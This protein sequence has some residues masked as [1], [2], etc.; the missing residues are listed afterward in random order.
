[1]RE[2]SVRERSVREKPEPK[3]KSKEPPTG[4]RERTS[5]TAS[6]SD[7]RDDA[8]LEAGQQA[9]QRNMDEKAV[10]LAKEYA[11]IERQMLLHQISLLLLF[12]EDLPSIVLNALV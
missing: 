8:D 10:N 4:E 2:R 11:R 5:S 7:N 9:A 12:L 6:N 1:M 3:P